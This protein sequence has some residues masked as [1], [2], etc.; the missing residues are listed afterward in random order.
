MGMGI[1]G[2]KYAGYV[3]GYAAEGSFLYYIFKDKNKDKE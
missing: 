3:A 1:R 2:L